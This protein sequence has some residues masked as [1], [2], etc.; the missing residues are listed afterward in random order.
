MGISIL[1]V[2][3]FPVL[4]A[5]VLAVAGK[6]RKFLV[7]L[8]AL[9]IAVSG[10]SLVTQQ[11]L[12]LAGTTA[13]MI[14]IF[15]AELA[16]IIFL[17]YWGLKL[18][19]L[20]II[21][22]NLA[23]LG[24]IT[25]AKLTGGA[26]VG[27][28]GDLL[29]LDPLAK[30]L[31]LLITVI[32]PLI[33][34]FA[35]AYMDEYEKAKGLEKSKQGRFFFLLFFFLGGMSLLVTAN[36]F[37]LVALGW[38][39]TTLCSF[40][41]IGHNGDE[42]SVKNATTALIINSF[43]G[44]FLTLGAFLAEDIL[45]VST[46]S[47]LVTADKGETVVMAALALLVVAG[48][49]KAAQLPFQSWLLGAMVAPTP[50]SALLHSSTMV[51]AGVYLILRLA[52]GYQDTMLSNVLALVGGFTFLI[53]S[54]LAISQSNG[55]RILAYST[56]ANLGLIVMCAGVNTP[57]ALGAAIFLIIFHAVSKA[58]LFL[59]VGTIELKNGSKDIETMHGLVEKM[60]F[61]AVAAMIG[62][63]TM[64][65]PPFGMVAGKLGAMEAAAKMP[66]V[67]VMVAFGSALTLVF[68]LRWAGSIMSTT[69]GLGEIK[70]EKTHLLISLPLVLL[71]GAGIVLSLLTDYIYQEA[72]IAVGSIASPFRQYMIGPIFGVLAVAMVA[73][74]FFAA[75]AKRQKTTTPYMCGETYLIQQDTLAFVA[76]MDKPV[77]YKTSH[78]YLGHWFAEE[79]LTTVS[80][81]IAIG[82]IAAM[83]GVI[84]P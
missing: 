74:M 26:V 29:V 33:C 61:V 65:L 43:G 18:K 16:V 34:V 32:G 52:P 41:L 2:T 11:E 64:F 1:G 12:P 30:V 37:S 14:G 73:G 39:I 79:R 54:A 69:K 28:G 57:L 49:T 3:L 36:H 27:T 6:L 4:A 81:I 31:I 76:A 62:M 82:L 25:Y 45:K 42:Q 9:I 68:W 15:I 44:L 67:V 56:I 10:L 48:L 47:Q 7:P 59:C 51:K 46:I 60:P 66:A 24:I 72:V 38:E 53:T 55:K 77:A 35:V 22:F 23:Q 20:W 80:N 71:A 84:L 70:Q 75:K 21:I 50:V 83:I 78:Y 40:M 8:S 5:L 58:L 17:L 13:L 63:I 19:N